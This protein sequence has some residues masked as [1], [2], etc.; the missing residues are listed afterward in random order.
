L[1]DFPISVIDYEMIDIFNWQDKASQMYSEM[2]LVRHVTAQEETIS[3]YI[4]EGR[5]VPDMDVPISEHRT[6]HYFNRERVKEFCQKYGWTEITSSNRKQLFLDFCN[7]MQ[8]SYS[9]K[10]VFLLSFLKN[11]NETGSA[12]LEDAAKDFA[13][14]Y[15]SAKSKYEPP[16]GAHDHRTKTART[17]DRQRHPGGSAG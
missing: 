15:V 1:V 5:I 8:M 14:Y 4:K 7:E 9:Y 2:E 10:P 13:A 12:K 3:R 16:G 6:L 17:E 11:M